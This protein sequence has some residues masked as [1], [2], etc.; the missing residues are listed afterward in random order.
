[1]GKVIDY[2][3]HREWRFEAVDDLEFVLKGERYYFGTYKESDKKISI[4]Y[5]RENSSGVRLIYSD[6]VRLNFFDR[7][8]RT[9]LWQKTIE[10]GRIAKSN[11]IEA[12]KQGCLPPGPEE[13]AR[14]YDLQ[15]ERMRRKAKE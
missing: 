9:K 15:D 7:L 10:M 5:F 3:Y 2:V 8:L 4:A 12:E 13:G 1:M 6:T 14:I 11:I